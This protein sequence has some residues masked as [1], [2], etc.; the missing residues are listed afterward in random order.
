MQPILDHS[1]LAKTRAEEHDAD[2]WGK[3]FIPPY[4]E[5]LALKQATKSTYLVGK[6]GC[7]KTMLLKYLDYHTLFSMKREAIPADEISHIGIY[8][9]VDTQ[10][11]NSLK[12]RGVDDETWIS[13]FQ[14]Y[15]SLVI[16]AEILRSVKAIASSAYPA[17]D[18]QNL[19]SVRF[20]SATEFHES[21][22]SELEEL[23]LF[24]ESKRRAFSLWVSNLSQ[25]P[26]PILPPGKDF[27]D[28][29]IAD[30]RRVKGL[31][32]ACFYV[33]VDE[34]ENLVPYQR[35]VLNAFLRHSQRPL[36][37]SFTS[38]EL[39]DENMTIGG[40]SINATHDYNLE[41]IDRLMDDQA[42]SCFFA[43]VFLA[44]L[45]I[46]ADN[47]NSE[48]LNVVL[49]QNAVAIR[50]S[51]EH[52][53]SVLQRIRVR[54]PTKEY[55]QFAVDAINT[56][57]IKT[58]LKD[59]ITK[60]LHRRG[61]SLAA[62]TLFSETRPAEAL[63]L[64]P[65]LI[66]RKSLSPQNILDELIAYE[67]DKSG[68]FSG[69]IHNNL[70]G[71]LLELYRPFRNTCPLYS[72]FD[73]FYTMANKNLRHFLIIC[74]KALELAE[75]EDE[76]TDEFSI[77]IQARAA[78]EASDQLIREI[79]TFG[80]HGEQLRSFVLRLGNI[81][82]TLQAS[83]SMSEPEQNQFTINSGERALDSLEMKFLSEAQKYAILIEML[84]TKTKGL[85]GSDITDFQL[86]PIYSPYFLIS[87]RRKRKIEISVEDFH[88]LSMGTENDYKELAASTNKK[89][90]LSENTQ[91]GLSL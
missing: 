6:R 74:Y 68:K 82:R 5:K 42:R 43:E 67:T 80:E 91:L 4:F 20:R 22:P 25:V 52:R 51:A 21:F 59:R 66:S 26:K 45:D 56:P 7:G 17:F 40:E 13:V 9:R 58:I 19:A 44:N 38:K 32:S 8:W 11:C 27:L 3:F 89:S 85:V 57:R 70:F 75:L 61:S 31:E 46:A 79:K 10:F 35:R 62:E 65:A 28:A 77:E 73:T 78:Y 1:I 69:W 86:N 90:E 15:F 36:I 84:E 49:D 53:D 48:L 88:T 29:L 63:V 50:E 30:I 83:P 76:V 41:Y 2:V 12:L 54:F 55:K 87:Y 81:F 34:V 18:A 39:S 64:L 60:A 24:L 71:A 72:G 16:S 14:S 37:V 23:E 33:Y 47:Q